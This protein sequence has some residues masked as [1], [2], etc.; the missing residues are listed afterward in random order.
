PGSAQLPPAVFQRP[1]GHT[2]PMP[3]TQTPLPPLR[4]TVASG[5]DVCLSPAD[6]PSE[7]DGQEWIHTTPDQESLPVCRF[8]HLS[9]ALLHVARVHTD[10]FAYAH[11]S[12]AH[13]SPHPS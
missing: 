1:C 10:R 13:V 11:T 3:Y 7:A 5:G 9:K 8:P 4:P 6:P 2:R 12:H